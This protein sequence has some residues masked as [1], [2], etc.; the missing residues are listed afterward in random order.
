AQRVFRQLEGFGSYGFPESH[1]ASFALL[2]YVSSWIKCFYPDIFACALLNSMPMGFYQPAQIVIDAK[3]HGVEVRPV[4]INHSTWDNRLEEKSGAYCVLR[5]G[6]RQVKGL[7]EEDIGLIIKNRQQHYTCMNQLREIGLSQA[8]LEKLADADAFRSMGLDRRQ[9]LW[10]VSVKDNPVALF[11][12]QQVPA[13]NVS[14]PLMTT[15]EHVVQDY[16]ATSLSLKAHPVSFIRDKLQQLHITPTAELSTLRDGMSVKVAGLVLVRQRPGTAGGICFM[17]IEDETGFANLVI[18]QSL[19]EQFRKPILQSRLIMAEG[20]VQ[21]EGEVIHVIVKACYDFSRLL[22]HLTPAFQK[23]P[24]VNTL[25]RADEKSAPPV[26]DKRSQPKQQ[27]KLFPD[28][29]NFK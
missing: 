27:E 29:R 19:F 23:D 22:R 5:L 17:T 28:A 13:E 2:V 20:K 7:R 25:S 3:K 4:D 18:F 8:V 21:I 14:L 16:A 10:E 11:R 1:A 26:P 12:Q 24:P 15:S 6:F 9:A